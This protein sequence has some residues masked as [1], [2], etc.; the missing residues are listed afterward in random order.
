MQIGEQHM[1]RRQNHGGRFNCLQSQHVSPTSS[2]SLVLVCF[3]LR[4]S[5]LELKTELSGAGSYC[6]IQILYSINSVAD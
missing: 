4:V 2:S 5:N 1:Y 6:S 3:L